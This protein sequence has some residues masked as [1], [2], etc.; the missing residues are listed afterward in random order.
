MDQEN[1]F[2]RAILLQLAELMKIA[3]AIEKTSRPLP[4]IELSSK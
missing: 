3:Q 1:T 2:E 4:P